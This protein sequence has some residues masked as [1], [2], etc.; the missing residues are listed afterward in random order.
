MAERWID[1]DA[2]VSFPDA[3]DDTTIAWCDDVARHAPHRG[4]V[5]IDGIGW[6]GVLA[7]LIPRMLSSVRTVAVDEFPPERSLKDVVRMWS[8]RAEYMFGR[9]TIVQGTS[10]YAASLLR[11]RSVDALLCTVERSRHWNDRMK[12]GGLVK[13]HE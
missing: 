8:E 2:W 5:V 1:L 6:G 12:I 4:I 3:L 9:V 10:E 11:P 7:Y 13:A